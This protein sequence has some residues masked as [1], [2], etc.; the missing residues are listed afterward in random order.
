MPINLLYTILAVLIISAISL[1]GV[2]AL[3]IKQQTLKK[4]LSFMV[5]FSVGALIGDAFLHLLP[6]SIEGGRSFVFISLAIFVGILSFFILEKFLRWRHCHDLS[7]HDHPRHIGV[8]NLVGDGFHNLID[9]ILIGVSFAVS[10]PLGIATSIA[11]IL[12]EVPQ[13]LGDFSVLMHSGFTV[14]KALL[15]NFL[16]GSLAVVSAIS[17]FF[18][19]NQ[20]ESFTIFMIPFTIGTF[21]YI[22]MSD[23]IPELHKETSFRQGLIQFAG[24]SLGMAIML[25]LLVVER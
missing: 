1:V 12:H 23:L 9:G 24:L 11:I 17:A 3:A 10:I 4:A 14:K 18:I 20:A 21:I 16:S 5:S 19:G 2:F 25:I 22:A 13:E 6:E 15:W 7:C 8:I